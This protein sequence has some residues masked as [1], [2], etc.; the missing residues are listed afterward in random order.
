M[1]RVRRILYPTDFSRASN[2]AFAR[3]IEMARANK[4]ELLL[5]H[6]LTPVAPIVGDGYVSPQLYADIEA[7]AKRKPKSD[8]GC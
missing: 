8:S 5:T 1:G 4:T 2:A 6:V 3:A 7:N